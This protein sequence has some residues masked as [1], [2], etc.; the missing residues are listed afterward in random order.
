[1]AGEGGRYVTEVRVGENE[2]FEA[3]LRRFTKKVQADGI[4][5]EARRRAHYEK[6]SIKRKKKDAA[7]RRKSAKSTG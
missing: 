5:T 4:L 2:P 1:M 7:K 6:P 3:A